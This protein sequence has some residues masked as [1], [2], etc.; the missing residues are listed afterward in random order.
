MAPK[1]PKKQR[2]TRPLWVKVFGFG[3]L[4]LCYVLL[5]AI[6]RSNISSNNEHE[7]GSSAFLN[8]SVPLKQHWT[9]SQRPGIGKEKNSTI[10]YPHPS[11]STSTQLGRQESIVKSLNLS[12]ASQISRAMSPVA[13]QD[14]N[15]SASLP[16]KLGRSNGTFALHSFEGQ[17][18][19][20]YTKTTEDDPSVQKLR[21]QGVNVT[22]SELIDIPSWEQ[23]TDLFGSE[24]VILGL[25]SCEAYRKAVPMQN[26]SILPAGN[27]NT[28]TNLFP[29][30]FHKNCAGRFP[31]DLTQVNWG[32]HNLADAR[33]ANYVVNKTKYQEILAENT[34][35]VVMVRHPVSWMFSTC[36][37]SYAARWRHNE[38][39][40]PH[41][42]HENRTDG[43][44]N[45]VR[46][47]YGWNRNEKKQTPYKSLIHFWREWIHSYIRPDLPFPR[48]IIRLEDIVFR[49]EAVLKKVCECA[50]GR[51][52]NRKI[53]VP[54]E[55]VKVQ[56]DRLRKKQNRTGFLT[57]GKETAGLLAAWSKHASTATLWQKITERDQR[58]IKEVLLQKDEHNLLRKLRYNLEGTVQQ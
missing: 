26:R 12:K 58:I 36:L 52:R 37:H 55:S 38:R 1:P 39:N 11:F 42:L 27:F 29:E 54:V 16:Q 33:L 56:K 19:K 3:L 51:Q 48:L 57:Q 43:T 20:T 8:P 44:L 6:L 9:T 22:E 18:T 17:R 25:E 32:K 46:V 4:G 10:I 31:Q 5:I 24:P 2:L 35:A 28:G 7:D 13:S 30:F 15:P 41:L 21:M 40:C 47:F 45:Y 49:P 23:V 14:D 50:G 34:L 53:S